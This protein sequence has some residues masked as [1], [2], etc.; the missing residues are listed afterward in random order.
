[1]NFNWSKQFFDGKILLTIYLWK[2]RQENLLNQ[3]WFSNFFWCFRTLP[4]RLGWTWSTSKVIIFENPIHWF[5]IFL[6][7]NCL[8]LLF[9]PFQRLKIMIQFY[10]CYLTYMLI[11]EILVV[12][13]IISSILKSF[14]RYKI[15]MW[16]QPIQYLRGNFRIL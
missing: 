10:K 11:L 1:M 12:K 9:T 6:E 5:R 4:Y 2:L 15:L 13:K 3:W 16:N 7:L 8:T 14:F